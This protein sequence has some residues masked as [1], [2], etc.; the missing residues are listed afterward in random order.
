MKYSVRRFAAAF[1]I[2]IAGSVF[3]QPKP[4][5]IVGLVELSGAGAT[6]G[7]NFNNGVKLAVKEINTAGAILGRKIEYTANARLPTR[8]R[9]Y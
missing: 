4:V 6:A 5:T 2:A 1:A 8:A 3:A 7:T 9:P